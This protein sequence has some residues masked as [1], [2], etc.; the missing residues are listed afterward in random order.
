[1][2]WANE[3]FHMYKIMGA[4]QRPY[5]PVSTDTIRE[6]IAQNRAN[7]ET[8]MQIEGG[9][10]WKPLAT[11]AE[12]ADALA[13]KSTASPAVTGL[14]PGINPPPPPMP[15]TRAYAEE[16]LRRGQA[17]D[18]GHCYRRAWEKL[19]SDFW[20]I[21]GV[22]ALILLLVAAAESVYVG[23]IINGPI[24]GGLN[25]YYLKHLRGERPTLNDA[26]AGFTMAFVPLMLGWL[27]TQVLV[28]VGLVLCVIPGI[29]LAVAWS[30]AL[31]LIIDKKFPF[32]EA[33]EVSRKVISGQWW[34]FLG[35]VVLSFL[36]TLAGA[37]A[38][39]VGLFVACPLAGLALTYAYEDIFGTPRSPGN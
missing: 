23:I 35:F 10:E 34:T 26:F 24:I 15:D 9:A 14:P 32:W 39:G 1:M 5:G 37:L 6:W 16:I 11:F 4:D 30:L 18:I 38:C 28:G 27:V 17:V 36:L 25:W 8:L 21:V 2:D 12:F 22:S 7:A 33:M 19:K 31:P 29:Y 3:R 20:P 13:A